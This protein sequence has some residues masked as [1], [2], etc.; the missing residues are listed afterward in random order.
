MSAKSITII[1]LALILIWIA[2]QPIGQAIAAI[3]GAI[4]TAGNDIAN[5]GIKI[6][7]G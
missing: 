1:V 4:Q 7:G 2:G 6:H 3:G 5:I